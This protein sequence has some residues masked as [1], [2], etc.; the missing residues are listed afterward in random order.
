MGVKTRLLII[1]DTHGK[2][3]PI[4]ED[5]QRA[6]V[7]IHCGDL[8]DE[9][10]IDEFRRTIELLRRLPVPLKLV[11]SGNHDLTL[12]E[13]AFRRALSDTPQDIE[14]DLI[15]REFGHFGESRRLFE[16]AKDAGIVFLDE[17]NYQFT[18]ENGANLRIYASPYTPS[19][20]G[21]A[22][23][24][25]H[26][27][28]HDFALAEGTHVSVTH[29]P[30]KG[31]MDYTDSK[32]RAG[33]PQLFSA[34]A[35]TKPL[36]HCFGHI[37]EGWGA[38]LVTWRDHLGDSPS[39]FSAIDNDKSLVIEKLS[40]LSPSK[41][42]TAESILEKT[43]RVQSYANKGCC[44]TSHCLGDKNP[45]N[46]GTQTLFINASIQGRE[47]ELPV[48][49]PWIVDIELPISAVQP[50]KLLHTPE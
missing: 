43:Q 27:T 22:F 41:F 33:C 7:A 21:G 44:S 35:K 19:N 29:G 24:Y 1:S 23:Q 38:K 28:N 46:H 48:H 25:P 20:G 13:P 45:I 17:G 37:H 36:L 47:N 32:K 42:D 34:I 9:S 39:H 5:E 2:I 14:P 8:T 12:D 50:S 3:F 4:H 10:K 40:N 16:E 15:T 30:P 18:L 6:D 26:H 31:I 49:P 11:I